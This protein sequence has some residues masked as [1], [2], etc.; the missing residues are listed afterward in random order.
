MSVVQFNDVKEKKTTHLK[1]FSVIQHVTGVID[2]VDG[3]V[4]ESAG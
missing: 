3:E 2:G 4:K 1:G